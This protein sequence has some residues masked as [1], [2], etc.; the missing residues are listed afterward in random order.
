MRYFQPLQVIP[1]WW[2]ITLSHDVIEVGTQQPVQIRRLFAGKEQPA[3]QAVNVPVAVKIPYSAPDG[4]AVAGRDWFV[5]GPMAGQVA[6]YASQAVSVVNVRQSRG[7]AVVVVIYD[8]GGRF[9]AFGDMRQESA[10][11]ESI[12][13]RISRAIAWDVAIKQ[14]GKSGDETAFL[15]DE[16]KRC[17]F[18]DVECHYLSLYG[19]RGALGVL[20]RGG[21]SAPTG[22]GVQTSATWAF[23]RD[24]AAQV[25]TFGE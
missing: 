9:G 10:A 5:A 23:D 16:G 19:T 11:A 7:V 13:Y 25:T 8:A 4:F 3:G 21:A 15:A 18:V 22:L 24:G 14:G 20:G 2:V 6:D 1:C 12:D 17:L